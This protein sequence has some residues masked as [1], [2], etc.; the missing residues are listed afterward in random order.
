M[1]N[2]EQQ[3]LMNDY[4]R[5]F[6]R[7]VALQRLGFRFLVHNQDVALK[8]LGFRFLVHNQDV[9]VQ[10]LGFRFLVHNQDV[11]VQRLGFRFLVH[12]QDVAVQR[13]YENLVYSHS[14]EIAVHHSSLLIVFD[15]QANQ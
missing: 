8:R 2:D 14:L 13:L 7:D 3:F 5:G 15:I 6:R 9:A 11:A 1:K 4:T 10:R 12:N